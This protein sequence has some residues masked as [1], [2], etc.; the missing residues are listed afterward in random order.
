MIFSGQQSIHVV[1]LPKFKKSAKELTNPLDVWC[2]F[3]VHGAALDTDNLP[4]ALRTSAV[5]RAMEVLQM[6]TQ[7]DLE[8]ERYLA[9]LKAERDRVSFLNEAVEE[10]REEAREQGLK[11]GLEQGREQ[12]LQKG[13]ILGRIHLC[14]RL[15]KLP[16]TPRQELIGLSLDELEARAVAMEHQAGIGQA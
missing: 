6:L 13:E 1:E 14:Q 12:G 7:N 5:Q 9:R 15:L 3:L 16:L 8:R 2:Y 4:A 10:A 11:Q